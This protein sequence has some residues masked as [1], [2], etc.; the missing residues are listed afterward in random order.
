[1]KT[2][3]M[4]SLLLSGF[5]FSASAQKQP[6]FTAAP[7]TSSFPR[8]EWLLCLWRRATFN[9]DGYADLA[10]ANSNSNNVTIASGKRFCIGRNDSSPRGN[11]PFTVWRQTGVTSS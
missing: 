8:R 1:M 10:V 5:E 4:L 9:G 2:V 3:L 11:G 7:G 6:V